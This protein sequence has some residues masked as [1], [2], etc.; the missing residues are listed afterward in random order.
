MKSI[1][2]GCFASLAVVASMAAAEDVIEVAPSILSVTSALMDQG[3]VEDIDYVDFDGDQDP[4]ALVIT[5]ISPDGSNTELKEW[6]VIDDMDGLGVQVGTWYGSD[7]RSIETPVVRRGDPIT[8]AVYS[9]GSF[10]Y[11]YKGKMRPYGDLVSEKT[12]FI[13]KGQS[14]QENIFSSFGFSDVPLH[15][16]ARVTLDLTDKNS[17]EVLTSLVGEG[18]W[19]EGDGATPYV[20]SDASGNVLHSGWSFTH[21]SV[22]RLPDGGFQLIEAVNG[23]YRAVFFPEKEAE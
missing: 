14:G 8:Y 10:W 20:L 18:F 3:V 7:V 23:G 5:N 11:L 19:R 22:Y 12:R 21:P 15:Y 17:D 13:H 4:E 6:R 16:M 9:D 1:T 2:F